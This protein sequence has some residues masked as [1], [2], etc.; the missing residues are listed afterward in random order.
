MSASLGR[1]LIVEDEEAFARFVTAVATGMGYE[2]R[3]VTHSRDF[4]FQLTEWKPI[5]LFLDVFMP[6]RDGLELLGLLQRQTYGGQ[7]VMMSGAD[8]LYLN[9]A[10][11]SA[12]VRGLRL[13]ATLSKPCRKQEIETLL[14]QLATPA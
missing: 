6:D 1:L 13:A 7:I 5:V 8:A 10:A 11:A 2:V 4:E 12:K 3:A 9:M 14:Q